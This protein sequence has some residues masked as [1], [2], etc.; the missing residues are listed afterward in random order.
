MP[1][2]YAILANEW[3]LSRLRG[4]ESSNICL[5]LR[6]IITWLAANWDVPREERDLEVLLTPLFGARPP[7][8]FRRTNPMG[9]SFP[10]HAPHCAQSGTI[11]STSRNWVIARAKERFN[12]LRFRQNQWTKG[13]A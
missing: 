8:S 13:K 2:V 10:C 11:T 1:A 12:A 3:T 9:H 7:S 4:W 6:L 5:L